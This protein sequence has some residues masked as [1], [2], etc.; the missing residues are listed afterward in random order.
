[1]PQKYASGLIKFT[2]RIAVQVK[3]AAQDSLRYCSDLD[4]FFAVG[5]AGTGRRPRQVLRVDGILQ[6]VPRRLGRVVR[7]VSYHVPFRGPVR[8]SSDCHYG[9]LLGDRLQYVASCALGG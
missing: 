1:M 5:R 3:V 2:L 6:P 9:V 8:L 7:Q 4:R